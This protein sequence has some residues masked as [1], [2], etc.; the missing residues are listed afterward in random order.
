[1]DVIVIGNL[2]KVFCDSSSED[3]LDYEGLF[4]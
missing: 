4:F 1:M 3:N 2:V